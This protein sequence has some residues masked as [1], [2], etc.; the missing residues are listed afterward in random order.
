MVVAD[1]IVVTVVRNASLQVTASWGSDLIELN[2]PNNKLAILSIYIW[3]N[4]AKSA[5]MSGHDGSRSL[6]TT[7][8][9]LRRIY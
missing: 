7:V 8:D 5:S 2:Q 3:T 6:R 1:L 9:L 4:L